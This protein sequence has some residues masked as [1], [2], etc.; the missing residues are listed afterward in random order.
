MVNSR[1]RL[2]FHPR[3]ILDVSVPSTPITSPNQTTFLEV[4]AKGAR[5]DMVFVTRMQPSVQD[6]VG[7]VPIIA[8]CTEEDKVHIL[9]WGDGGFAHETTV[10]G[11]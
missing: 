9:Y 2:S 4:A 6:Q 3:L 1:H 11:L 5:P 8:I 10:I 7:Y